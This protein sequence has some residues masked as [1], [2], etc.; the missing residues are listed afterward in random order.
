MAVVSRHIILT[1]LLSVS[2]NAAADDASQFGLGVG[3]ASTQK[4]YTGM[5]R[6]YTPLPR[7]YT[8]KRPLS[9]CRTLRSSNYP[10]YRSVKLSG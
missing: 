3:V 5:D 1:G 6:E 8:M 10:R 7:F 2:F 9:L 4:P